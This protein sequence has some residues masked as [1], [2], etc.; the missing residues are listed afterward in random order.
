MKKISVI[1]DG[2]W[3][4]A[5]SILMQSKGLDVVLWSV[6]S[7][8]A[9]F[10][11]E[12]RENTKFL[13]G[14]TLPEGLKITS[15]V[16]DV[17]G[18]DFVFFVVPCE[19]LR[20]VAE[21]FSSCSFGTIISAT[22]GIENTSLK[23][24]SEILSEFYDEEKINVLSGPSISFEVARGIPT[25]VVVASST[26]ARNEVQSLLMGDSFRVYTS[27]DILGVELGGALKNVIAI[28]SGISDGLG[29]GTNTKAAILTRGLAEITRLGVKMGADSSTFRGLSGLGDLAT[30]CISPHSRNRW[31]GQE[32]GKGR[33]ISD[34]KAETEMVI[35]GLATSESAYELAKKHSVTMPITEKVY[36][37]IYQ[38]KNPAQAV[39]EL[40]TREAKEEDYE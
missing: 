6:S 4:T 11:R 29:F 26:D 8:Y 39:K 40:M 2:G 3:G 18:S 23:R 38:G 35:E 27:L 13:E 20:E 14:I 7:D 10:L 37:M 34:V 28:A 25:T 5:L 32:I 16:E 33:S 30:T 15:K 21:K 19:Y 36:E 31:F 1:G 9:E 17:D 22:K 12:K 24:A